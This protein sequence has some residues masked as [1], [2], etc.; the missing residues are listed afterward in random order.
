MVRDIQ[1]QFEKDSAVV[2]S[3][4]REFEIG[5]DALD[6]LGIQSAE[7]NPRNVSATVSTSLNTD[8]LHDFE[9]TPPGK[10]ESHLGGIRMRER[11]GTRNAAMLDSTTFKN[12]VGLL[13]GDLNPTA[14]RFFDLISFVYAV[15]LYDDVYVT[16]S[17]NL[18]SVNDRIDDT[19]FKPI[20]P[21]D[22]AEDNFLFYLWYETVRNLDSLSDNEETELRR[23]WGDLLG[24]D[25]SSVSFD[26]SRAD[27]WVNSPPA[28]YKNFDR[29]LPDAT[30]R[31][32]F[33]SLST[34]RTFYS[35]ELARRLDL[36]YLPN[37]ARGPAEQLILSTVSDRTAEFDAIVSEFERILSEE[38][39]DKKAAT[40]HLGRSIDHE[41]PM[42]LAVLANRIA[43]LD[44]TFE[45]LAAIRNEASA[46]RKN[47]RELRTAI[48]RGDLDRMAEVE[49]VLEQEATALSGTFDTG[50]VSSSISITPDIPVLPQTGIELVAGLKLLSGFE[51]VV[52][53]HGRNLYLRLR[54]PHYYFL[55]DVHEEARQFTSARAAVETLWGSEGSIDFE[56]FE[57][58]RDHYPYFE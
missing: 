52:S 45:T 21:A 7:P 55:T 26:W 49:S 35:H 57:R 14:L 34:F 6:S 44:E 12:S 5:Y 16:S 53:Q 32:R 24:V 30:H 11:I 54:K 22:D 1:L 4:E 25:H 39:A 37:S 33:V 46:Y 43:D 48:D 27:R 31:E 17:S 38:I 8:A 2:R 58:A 42:F 36:E 23:L 9:D 40:P 29:R 47:A 28:F 3:T 56:L 41:L 18:E 19:V 13:R 10:Q 15:V 51:S 50:P 20:E